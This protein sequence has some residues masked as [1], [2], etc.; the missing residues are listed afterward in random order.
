MASSKNRDLHTL[1]P[2]WT[3]DETKAVGRNGQVPSFSSEISLCAPAHLHT[4]HASK[5]QQLRGKLEQECGVYNGTAP[6][7]TEWDQREIRRYCDDK[8][9]LQFLIARQVRK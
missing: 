2:T 1:F 5:V 3:I 7:E 9:L 6:G 8:I 4:M